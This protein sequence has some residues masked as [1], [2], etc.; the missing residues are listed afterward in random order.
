MAARTSIMRS[1]TVALL[2]LN[3]ILD[4][5]PPVVSRHI[6]VH[7]TLVGAAAPRTARRVWKSV[8]EESN[9]EPIRLLHPH[10]SGHRVLWQQRGSLGTVAG[11]ARGVRLGG[12]HVQGPLSQL[13]LRVVIV[14]QA[15]HPEPEH[16]V[17][18][19]AST[20]RVAETNRKSSE[21]TCTGSP[22]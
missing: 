13:P 11:D 2:L 1:K 5:C 4:L 17:A 15:P 3:S 22:E 20:D 7:L 14:T 21:P 9:P 8:A 6:R 10:L 12:E 19:L 18:L 16:A